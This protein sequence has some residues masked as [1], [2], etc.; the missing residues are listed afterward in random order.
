[1]R[2]LTVT[3]IA[4]LVILDITVS[5]VLAAAKRCPADPTPF[6]RPSILAGGHFFPPQP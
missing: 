6:V 1:M 3:L 4:V 5:G 2:A